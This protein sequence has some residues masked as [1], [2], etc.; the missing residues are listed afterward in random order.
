VT[1]VTVP[2][3]GLPAESTVGPGNPGPAK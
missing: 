1:Q 3:D 2:V